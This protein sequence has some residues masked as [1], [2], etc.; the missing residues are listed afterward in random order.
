MVVCYECEHTRHVCCDCEDVSTLGV[1][2]CECAVR[3]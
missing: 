1:S 3:V 2:G